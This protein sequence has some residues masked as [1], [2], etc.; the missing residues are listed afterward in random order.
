M[1][2]Q[3]GLCMSRTSLKVTTQ[4]SVL[5]TASAVALGQT[6]VVKLHLEGP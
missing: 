6:S 2:L 1:Q 5:L 4:G 3:A